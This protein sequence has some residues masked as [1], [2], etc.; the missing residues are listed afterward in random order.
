MLVE[1]R[2]PAL[3]IAFLARVAIIWAA[4]AGLLFAAKFDAVMAGAAP[5][6]DDIMR[7]M[8][9]RDLLAGQSWFDVTQYRVDAPGGGVPMHW[10]RIVDAP[11]VMLILGLSPFIGMASAETAAVVIVPLVTLLIAM[12]L[13]A[14]IAWRLFGNE[15]ATMTALILA[16]SFPILLQFGPTRIDHHGWQ[17]VCALA[18][19]NGLM[20]RNPA[21]GGRVI[22]AALAVWLLISIEG[23]PLAAMMFAMLALRWLRA[24]GDRVILITA[25]Q[26]FAGTG[27]VLFAATR[28]IGDLATYCDAVSPVHLAAFAFG[29]GSLTVLSKL[30]PIP[31]GLQV[32]VLAMIGAGAVGMVALAAPQCVTGGGFAELDPLVAEFWHAYIKEGLPIWKQQP[33]IMIIYSITPVIGLFA[34]AQLITASRDWLRRYWID[35]TF[36]LL[37]SVLVSM[38]V[39]RAGSVACAL[40]APPVAWKLC[41]WIRAITRMKRSAPRIA[42]SAMLAFAIMPALVLL[43]VPDLTRAQDNT[44]RVVEPADRVPCA[45]DDMAWHLSQLKRGEIFAPLDISPDLLFSHH[46]VVATSHHRGNDAM[47]FVIATSLS[48]PDDARSALRER[49]T[50]YVMVCPGLS[51]AGVYKDAAPGGF[52]ALLLDGNAP[53]WLEAVPMPAETSL[54]VWRVKSSEVSQT[55]PS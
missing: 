44:P 8:Q 21:T 31:R 33:G 23:L 34:S 7:L 50:D 15:Q 41:E 1:R 40:A 51:E 54:N 9:V 11:I 14:R 47:R 52:M 48:S 28:G 12:I 39:I 27:I 42:A 5:R 45:I 49:G 3:A 10:S 53:T 20:A 55:E 19:L 25:A 43:V 37:G 2:R 35:Y 16:L 17:V 38:F 4:I 32:A 6:P 29:A 18:A 24:R 30:E 26:W 46:S 22:G 13:C 36:I